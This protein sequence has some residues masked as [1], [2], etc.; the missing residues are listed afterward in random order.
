MRIHPS[1]TTLIVFVIGPLAWVLPPHALGRIVEHYPETRWNWLGDGIFNVQLAVSL[2]IVFAIGFVY[3]QLNPK[4][5]WLAALA[6][7]YVVPLNVALD[8]TQFPTSHN[9]FPFELAFFAV[10]NLPTLLGGRLGKMS[11]KRSPTT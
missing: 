7:W 6:T 2:P 1:V 9:L 4:R 3:G 5:F 8:V 11:A 10:L